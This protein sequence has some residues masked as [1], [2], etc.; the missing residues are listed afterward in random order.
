[1]HRPSLRVLSLSAALAVVACQDGG[2]NT[3]DPAP[4][5]AIQAPES[6]TVATE[7]AV[8]FIG[9][10]SDNDLPST[11]T[12]VWTSDQQEEPLHLGPP[13]SSGRMEFTSVLAV[14]EHIVELRV[15]DSAGQSDATSI[16]LVVSALA[17]P[18]LVTINK[19]QPAFAYYAGTPI[20]FE[21]IVTDS[22]GAPGIFSIEW[23]SD[24]FGP[25]YTGV[26]TADG[27][28]EFATTLDEG[29]H[30]IQLRTYDTTGT[31]AITAV[32]ITV[33]VLPPG[34]LDQDS[35]GYCPDGID[36]DGNGR[37]EGAEVTGPD[38][39]DCDDAAAPVCPGC[40]EVCDGFAVN[41][42]DGLDDPTDGDGDGDGWAP[43]EGDCNDNA[44]WNFPGNLEICDGLDNDCD[45]VPDADLAGE[46]DGDGDG[47]RSCADYDDGQPTNFPGNPEVCDGLDNDCNGVAD[48]GYD[49]DGDG[50]AVCDGDCDDGE[51]NSYPGNVEVCDGI[52]NNCAS[53]IDEGYDP[54]ND[55]WTSCEG[56]CNNNQPL[57]FPGNVESCDSVDND[58]DGSVDEGFDVDGDTWTVCEGDCNDLVAQAYPGLSEICDNI[59]NDCDNVIDDGYDVDGDGW[60]TCEGD[61]N[62]N[63]ALAYPGRAETCDNIDNDCDGLVDDGFDLDNDGWAT[64]EGD[65]NDALAAVHPNAAEL[66]DSADN[67]CDGL[68]NEEQAGLYEAWETSSSSPGYALSSLGPELVFGTGSCSIGGFLLLQPGSAS[69]SGVFSSPQDLWDIYEFDTGL[70]SNLAAWFAFVSS[71]SGLPSSCTTGSISWTSALPI[72]V[73]A[74]VDGTPH[75]GSGTS[76]TITFGLSIFQLFDVEYRVT[77]QPLATWT[78]CNYTYNLNFVIP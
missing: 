74:V 22:D 41:N 30:L 62:D 35:D 46:V 37:C 63:Q 78:N 52:D 50:F 56:D 67:D 26:T 4:L 70:T 71:G 55:G 73:T 60:T 20:Q 29:P 45:G 43:C 72:S 33:G 66:C 39:Q 38:T 58:C 3:Y 2:V 15:T 10:V 7:A 23:A 51:A 21:G 40:P 42:C 64:C 8:H 75:S 1:M 18:P 36:Q 11:L 65:C 68:V 48:D 32:E 77:V 5:A 25:L 61:C 31:L 27:L 59:D 34:Q 14:G 12:V 76:G 53:G 47:A 69:V 19:P 17:D 54:D 57:A 9:T 44:D 13:D 16:T 49:A 24:M 6:G 28:T